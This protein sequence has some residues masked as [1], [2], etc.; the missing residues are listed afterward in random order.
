MKRLS[1]T[2]LEQLLGDLESDRAERKA[3]WSGD[4][5]LPF[6]V[7]PITACSLD[8]I[9]RPIFEGEYLPN[10]FAPDVLEANER[11]YE[12]RLAACRMVQSAAEPVPT[13]LGVLALGKSPRT[14][15][16]GAYIQ[17]LR[18]SGGELDGP[19]SDEESIDG[20][21]STILRRSDEKS[22]RP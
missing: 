15:L 4:R 5:D 14:W 7:W 13:V 1:D 2:E 8:E 17:F 6:D 21:L 20:A 16:P 10:A 12:E 18:I 9:S 11:S 19:I 22:S 3:A